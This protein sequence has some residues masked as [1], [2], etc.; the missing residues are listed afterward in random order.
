MLFV[1]YSLRVTVESCVSHFVSVQCAQHSSN[2]A[3]TLQ[4]VWSN[5]FLGSLKVILFFCFFFFF[6]TLIETGI[7]S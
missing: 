2:I 5:L 1:S 4:C 7:G 3:L 6:K